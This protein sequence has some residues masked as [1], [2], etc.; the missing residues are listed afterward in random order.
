MSDLA[1][2]AKLVLR[3]SHATTLSRYRSIAA[4]GFRRSGGRGGSGVYFWAESKKYLDLARAWYD[5]RLAEG[6]TYAADERKECII[7]IGVLTAN[8]KQILNLE[9]QRFKDAIDTL[10]EKR[11]LD[12]DSIEDLTRLHDLFITSLERK[13]DVT[14]LIVRLRVAKPPDRFLKGYSVM[15]LGS[16]ESYIAR[17]PSIVEREKVLGYEGKELDL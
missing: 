8:R 5:W 16:P 11:G 1:A 12:S 3:G 17:D 14:F 9:E 10:A 4:E 6:T 2:E 15:R 13:W 7:I